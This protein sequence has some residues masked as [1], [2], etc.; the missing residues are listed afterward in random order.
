M[1]D[2]ATPARRAL[3]QRR[4]IRPR[5]LARPS[6]APNNEVVASSPASSSPPPALRA[7][8]QGTGHPTGADFDDAFFHSEGSLAP[9]A[10]AVAESADLD[11]ES[12]LE[13]PLPPPSPELLARQTR[14]RKV[15]TSTVA[16]LSVA[17]LFA[18]VNS[19]ASSPSTAAASL[20]SPP[21]VSLRDNAPAAAPAPIEPSTPVASVAQ[22]T[23]IEPPVLDEPEPAAE[24]DA[25]EGE[26]LA[27]APEPPVAPS[28]KTTNPAPLRASGSTGDGNAADLLETGQHE[29]AA[30]KARSLVQTDPLNA[31]NYLL[32]GGAYL[33]LNQPGKAQR[34]FRDCAAKAVRGPVNECKALAR[35]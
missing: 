17:A 4:S 19:A 14:L 18:G 22:A 26:A 35:N 33:E 32:L 13:E 30:A 12:D 6:A 34:A 31:R 20:S 5:A 24:A 21:A 8:V 25:P 1:S 10:T 15:V 3:R 11:F 2:K 9:T 7:E 23:P 29:A 16:V 27:A 28:P